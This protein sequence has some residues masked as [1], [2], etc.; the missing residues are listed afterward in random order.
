MSTIPSCSTEFRA[1]LIMI[2]RRDQGIIR[3]R[4]FCLPILD[5]GFFLQ[6]I[7]NLGSSV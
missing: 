4:Q 5:N 7:E 6:V 3:L 1:H 2:E